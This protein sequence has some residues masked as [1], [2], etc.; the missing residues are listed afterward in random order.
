MRLRNN[1]KRKLVMPSKRK[2][3]TSQTSGIKEEEFVKPDGGYG[4]IILIVAFVSK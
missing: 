3:V 4:W 1:K 2:S